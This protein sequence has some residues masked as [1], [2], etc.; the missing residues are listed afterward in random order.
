MAFGIAEIN[1]EVLN[2]STESRK[3]VGFPKPFTIARGALDATEWKQMPHKW[4]ENLCGTYPCEVLR[5]SEIAHLSPETK[6]LLCIIGSMG[7][8]L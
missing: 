2:T 7:L 3:C 6:Y 1:H 4:K 5:P 8:C